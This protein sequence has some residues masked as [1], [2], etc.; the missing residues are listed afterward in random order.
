MDRV[1]EIDGIEL[2]GINNRDLGTLPSK[3]LNAQLSIA[4]LYIIFL[5]IIRV[6]IPGKLVIEV[7]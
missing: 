6:Y 3:H 5:Y 7:Y 4:Q 2:I 1:L